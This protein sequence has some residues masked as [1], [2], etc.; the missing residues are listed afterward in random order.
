[1]EQS[2]SWEANYN[3]QETDIHFPDEI[4]TWPQKSERAQTHALH[5]ALT[6]IGIPLHGAT[7]LNRTIN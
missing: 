5:R 7:I 6:G 2:P 3:S 1:M 4:R